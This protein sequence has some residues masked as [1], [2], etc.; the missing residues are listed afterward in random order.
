MFDY[1][2]ATKSEL[3]EEY[4]NLSNA[5][6]KQ[7]FRAERE[8][9]LLPA[10]LSEGEE[11]LAIA[12]G[13][14][15]GKV[16]LIVLTE[17]RVIFL[18]KGEFLGSKYFDIRL[19]DIASISCETGFFNGSISIGTTSRTFSIRGVSKGTAN[20]FTSL[21]NGARKAIDMPHEAIPNH[22]ATNSTIKIENLERL[23]ALKNQGIL[24]EDEFISEKERILS[25]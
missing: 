23:A 16:W 18:D 8:F 5:I 13:L 22:T 11:P 12:S 17:Q 9:L 7:N 14:I 15:E 24:T 10:I 2:N 25:E 21:I 3:L 1:K 4:N 20:P 6:C 19:S